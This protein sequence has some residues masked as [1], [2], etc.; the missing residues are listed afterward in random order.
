MARKAASKKESGEIRT[1]LIWALQ[2]QGGRSYQA[3]TDF[4]NNPT[5][6]QIAENIGA[7]VRAILQ[8]EVIG[9]IKA[10]EIQPTGQP[11][12]KNGASKPPAAATKQAE[13]YIEDPGLAGQPSFIVMSSDVSMDRSKLLLKVRGGNFTAFGVPV[14]PEVAIESGIVQDEKEYNDLDP[15]NPPDL[16]G[17]VAYY[18][19][20]TT[21][22]G[23]QTARKILALRQYK[24]TS[25][26]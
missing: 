19:A 12:E 10:R 6:S 14:W 20:A 3:R 1:Q 9:D 23:T 24:Q 22:E 5:E 16:R 8:I 25:L 18:L 11:K 2:V 17:W 26:V 15:R 7:T 21:K 13:Q 4:V